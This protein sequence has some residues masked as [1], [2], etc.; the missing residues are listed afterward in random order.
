ML[1][2]TQCSPK[3]DDLISVLKRGAAGAGRGPVLPVA[4]LMM[5]II[6]ALG[7]LQYSS[8]GEAALN[9]T[10]SV[11]PML[12]VTLLAVVLPQVALP[13]ILGGAL[14]YA[15]ESAS[16]GKPGWKTFMDSGKKHYVSLLIA[17]VAAWVIFYMLALLATVLFTL[18]AISVALLPL[19]IILALAI[20]FICLMY[21]EFYDIAI[22]AEGTDFVRAFTA[23][24]A[25][26][27][28]HLKLV[29]PFFIIVVIV[30][31]LVQ[32]PIFVAI[33]IRTMAELVANFSYYNETFNG[34]FNSTYTNSTLMSVQTAPFSTPTLLSIA[35]M[36]ILAQ[37]VVFAF[38]I[39]Y[40]AEFYLW[41]KNLKKITD[42]D[43]D[44][45]SEK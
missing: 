3:M 17:G 22:V 43:Y 1:E 32:L 29:I 42:F 35:I 8:L 39:S 11:L 23:S 40:K 2:M 44:F 24:M 36:Q 26:V 28:K 12:V 7:L 19:M 31:L 38:V 18:G 20:M 13:F 37:A 33:F 30:K 21:I 16:G 34:T 5:G 4:G 10:S 15:L 9:D 41:A 27:S 6:S 45:S 25:F 14:G